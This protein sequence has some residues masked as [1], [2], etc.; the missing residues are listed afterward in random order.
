MEQKVI[1]ISGTKSDNLVN[2]YKPEQYLFENTDIADQGG[3]WNR[4]I[5]SVRIEDVE[6][7]Q[8]EDLDH[9]FQKLYRRNKKQYSAKFSLIFSPVY[10]V[11]RWLGNISGMAER[12]NCAYFTSSVRFF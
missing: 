1:N 4:N 2:F 6:D 8:I 9:Y 12:G 7:W 11:L 3:I 5:V 10:N